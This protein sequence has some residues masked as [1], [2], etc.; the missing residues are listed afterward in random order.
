MKS[1]SKFEINTKYILQ[2]ELL[3]KNE[4]FDEVGYE[5]SLLYN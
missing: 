3:Q 2:V 1:Y 4:A 5:W